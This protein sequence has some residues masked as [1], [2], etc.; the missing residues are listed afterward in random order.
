MAFLKSLRLSGL[1]SFPPDTPTLELQPLNVLIGP[2]GS[3]KSNFLEAIALL[4]SL[5][6]SLTNFLRTNGPVQDWLWKGEGEHER[7]SLEALVDLF[8]G[9]R[10]R[11]NLSLKNAMKSGAIVDEAIDYGSNSS[12]FIY[13][14]GCYVTPGEEF[15]RIKM[16]SGYWLPGHQDP[17]DEISHAQLN[18]GESILSQIKDPN[19]YPEL[20]SLG[21]KFQ[22]INTFRDWQFGRNAPLRR[23]QS[24][25]LPIEYLTSNSEN[26][27]LVLIEIQRTQA[28]VR[29]NEL[30]KRF[31]P[32]FER[33]SV[34]VYG[35]SIQVYFHENGLGTP[36]PA[37]RLSDGTIR[38]LALLAL[39]LSPSPPPL[40]CI[41]EPELSLHPDMVILLAD[42]LV[43]A[44]ERMQLIVTTHS[45]T[46]VSA[47]S[48]QVESV[49]VCDYDNGTRM[50]RMSSDELQH[51]L[52][53]YR[54][55]DLWRMGQIG[56]N[57]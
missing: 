27:G 26:L 12:D 38:F 16:R 40:L 48:H 4:H 2:N 8:G 32:R 13:Y 31:L 24:T 37:T 28:I 44:S 39:L 50:Q 22:K 46:L 35:N 36:I 53:D 9:V 21:E 33:L 29:F 51:W 30:M 19:V 49:I 14:Q 55:G 23:P 1:L 54:L 42:L 20:T 25:D 15:A 17:V 3:G 41:E 52:E 34:S 7:I 45:D 10:Y 57:P 18:S 43:E 47:L 56:G 11:L 6:N 5:P